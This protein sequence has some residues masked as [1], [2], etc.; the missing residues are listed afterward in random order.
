MTIE[1]RNLYIAGFILGLG[2]LGAVDGV[3]FHQF[4]QWHHLID[5]PN[6]RLEIISDG[7]FNSL[8]AVLL[9]WGG[10]KIFLHARN[11]QLSNNSRIF[12]GAIL[13][14]GGTFNIVE[15]LVNHHILQVH[16]VKPGDPYELYYDIGFLL[17]GAF[18]VS[19]GLFFYNVFEKRHLRMG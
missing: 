10:F 2:I 14:G 17:I 11:D 12:I 8:I 18:L 9:I 15:G 5:H 1:K 4:L 16:K 3:L 6:H 7:V 19:I 13:T